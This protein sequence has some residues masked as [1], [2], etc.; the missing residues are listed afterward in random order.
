MNWENHLSNLGYRLT[1]PRKVVMQILS[2]S[3]QPLAPLEIYQRAQKMDAHLGLVSVYRAME[4]FTDLGLV[5]R[6]H[7]ED[8]CHAYTLSSPGHNH[9]VI[10]RNCDKTVE[11]MGDEDITDLV[12]RVERMT[13]YRIEDHLLQFYGL[14][15]DCRETA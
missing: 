14:C 15:Q 5:R 8:G 12:G 7:L 3:A 4:L 2:A 9:T 1:S 10:C 11:F 13:G 6:M